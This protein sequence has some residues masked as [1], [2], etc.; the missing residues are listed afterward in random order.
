MPRFGRCCEPC[1]SRADWPPMT[2]CYLD[3]TDEI[4]D[5]VARLRTAQ[6][7]RFILFLPPGSRVSTSRINFRLLG[8]EGEAR[9]VTVAIVSPEAGVRALAVSAGLPVYGSVQEAEDALAEAGITGPPQA[10]ERSTE[11]AR[12]APRS[13]AP[14]GGAAVVAA[15]GA[16]ALADPRSSV[17][18]W[19]GQEHVGSRTR[20]VPRRGRA[21]GLLVRLGLLAALIAVGLY[22]AY[23]YLPTVSVRVQPRTT[24]AGPISVSVTADPAAGVPDPVA[25]VVPAQ[26]I[27]IPLSATGTF[28]STGAE[29]VE[30]RS[31]GLVRFTSEN[32]VTDVLVPE[33]TQVSTASGVEFETIESVTLD[34]ASFDTGPTTG[35][36][37][38][39]ALRAG[40]Q[41]NVAPNT[42]TRL[43]QSLAAQQ[44]QSTNPEA[45]GGGSREETLVVTREDFAAAVTALTKELDEQLAAALATPATAPRGLRLFP[46]TALRDE[47]TT[48]S[49][50]GDLVGT[51]GETFSLTAESRG[52]VN[53]VDEALVK[54]V[55][56]DRLAEGLDPGVRLFPDSIVATLGGAQVVSG[57]I[58]YEVT[59]RGEQYLPPDTAEMVSAIRGKK[60]SEA[61]GILEARGTVEIVP[62][63]DFIDT[64]PD[65]AR[66]ID[67]TV[68]EP[69]RSSQ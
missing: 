25:A 39:R 16:G 66:R 12:I 27:D 28:P 44:I 19:I 7:R 58:V 13:N 18:P 29:V 4:T 62:W 40:A 1:G 50:A 67:L 54:E 69:Q 21:F 9:G 52:T 15:A 61:R 35:D 60:L 59:V 20:A 14:S 26:R 46:E 11:T 23:L 65:D 2:V 8:R 6:D 41:G 49:A 68:L 33:G 32:T 43:S 47:V 34:R 17:P 22:A 38:V 53:A 42:L 64:V 31:V 45:M 37:Q 36:A 3:A 51:A 57:S 48:D 30:T 24:T 63:P 10:Q 55:A 56:A 5:A